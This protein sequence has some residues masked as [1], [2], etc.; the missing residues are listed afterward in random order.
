MLNRR[1]TEITEFTVLGIID[2]PDLQIPLFLVCFIIYLAIVLGNLGLIV[3]TKIDSGLK[4]PVYFFLRKLSFT[5]LECSNDIGPKMLINFVVEKNIIS[6]AGCAIQLVAFITLILSE[7]FM[8]SVLAYDSYVAMCNS[9]H[10]IV[11]MSDKMYC[12]LVIIPYIYGS[13]VALLTTIN[14]SN[15]SFWKSD[16][17]SHFCCDT[18]PLLRILCKDAKD[19]ELIILILS[20]FNLIYSWLMVLVSYGLILVTIVRMNSAEG[21]HKAFSTCVSHLTV[22]V[23]FYG[24]LTFIYLQAH[25]SHSFDTNKMASTCYTLLIPMLNCLIYSLKNKDVRGALKRALENKYKCLP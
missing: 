9:L 11:T 20:A 23:V 13:F 7:L 6:Y 24:T 10:Y 21:R 3:L 12:I 15:I 1:E 8:L 5:D 2:D 19:I 22:V 17:I 18:L 25:S 16:V 14:V 4:T